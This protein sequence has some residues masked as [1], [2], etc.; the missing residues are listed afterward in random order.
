MSKFSLRFPDDLDRLLDAEISRSKR[1][2]TD[3][4]KDALTQYLSKEPEEKTEKRPPD[5][6]VAEA[7]FDE[8]FSA[9][10]KRL[11]KLED[12]VSHLMDDTRNQF[13][14]FGYVLYHF[15]D[16]G[17]GDKIAPDILAQGVKS[18]KCHGADIKEKIKK[19]A[20][21]NAVLPKHDSGRRG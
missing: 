14:Y 6:L 10:V 7:V 12:A 18:L 20:E 11:E 9:V 16:A 5:Q 1:S 15:A 17:Y 21:K 4:I 3:V 13:E 19:G 8:K 2:R